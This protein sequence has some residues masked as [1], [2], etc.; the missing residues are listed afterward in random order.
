[1]LRFDVPSEAR[2]RECPVAAGTDPVADA[3]LRA[4]DDA[5]EGAGAVLRGVSHAAR[6]LQRQT[7]LFGL[8]LSLLQLLAE[9]VRLTLAEESLV[10]IR[11][12]EA[13]LVSRRV[14]SMWAG[15]A[16][17]TPHDQQVV[18]SSETGCL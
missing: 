7:E 4:R 3:L 8:L 6:V 14:F 16:N 1:V 13:A 10:A 2:L 11:A 17:S 9:S 15:I 5:A 12:E 18:D